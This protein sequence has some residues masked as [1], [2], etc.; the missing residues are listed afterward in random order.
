MQKIVDNGMIGFGEDQSK[1]LMEEAKK[2]LCNDKQKEL[3][4]DLQTLS[5][6]KED[7]ISLSDMILKLIK[8]YVVSPIERSYI[9]KIEKELK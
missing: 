1:A 8:Y 9:V 6:D 3:A 2:I 7:N 5:E 4:K